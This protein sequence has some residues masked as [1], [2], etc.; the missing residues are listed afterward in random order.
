M[1]KIQQAELKRIR[2][3]ARGP[4]FTTPQE[5]DHATWRKEKAIRAE[6]IVKQ[7]LLRE[8]A[9]LEAKEIR[10]KLAEMKLGKNDSA[11]DS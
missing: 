10:K 7:Q 9:R 5:F 6:N 2:K 8:Q 4:D 1:N 3:S 11:K